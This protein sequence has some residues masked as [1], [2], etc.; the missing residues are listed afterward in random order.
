MGTVVFKWVQADASEV[1]VTGTFDDWKQTQKLDRNGDIFEKEVTLP[2]V[3][4]NIYY[5]VRR[6][7]CGIRVHSSL[8]HR[9]SHLQS[10]LRGFKAMDTGG[11]LLAPPLTQH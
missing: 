4:D 5:K 9:A 11:C 7:F 10:S 8:H 1:L 6:Q 3:E 2:S